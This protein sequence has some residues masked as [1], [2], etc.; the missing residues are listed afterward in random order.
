[1]V[2]GESESSSESSKSE[3]A[4][5]SDKSKRPLK[6]GSIFGFIP[7]VYIAN[8][9]C[10]LCVFSSVDKILCFLFSY[11]VCSS[12]LLYNS[13]SLILVL[14]FVR[15]VILCELVILVINFKCLWV[16]TGKIEVTTQLSAFLVLITFQ[17][18]SE[19]NYKILSSG[20]F[21]I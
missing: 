5:T 10:F 3:A 12:V 8:F 14:H 21:S 19:T 4:E 16:P 18:T 20:C 1:M 13:F 6:K 11:Y 2:S 7:F 17:I 9:M 15:K